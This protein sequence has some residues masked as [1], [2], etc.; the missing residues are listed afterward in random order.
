MISLFEF[1]AHEGDAAEGHDEEADDGDECPEGSGGPEE[2]GVE[3]AR[4]IGIGGGGGDLEFDG[5]GGDGEE[6]DGEERIDE[7][8]AAQALA[9]LLDGHRIEALRQ[10]MFPQGFHGVEGGR[11]GGGV[12]AVGAGRFFGGFFDVSEGWRVWRA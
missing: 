10:V 6:V 11:S 9:Q 12:Q 4:E 1:L 8:A 2:V 7:A 5:H 3:H